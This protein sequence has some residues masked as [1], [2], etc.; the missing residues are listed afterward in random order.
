MDFKKE[1]T[2]AYDKDAH[3]RDALESKR[4]QWKLDLRKQFA[5]LLRSNNK[6]SVLELGSGAGLDAAFFQ[7][8]GFDVLATDLSPEMIKM[9][10]KRGL[11]AQVSDLYNLSTLNKKFDSIFSMNVLLHVPKRDLNLVLDNIAQ[12]LTADGIFFYGVY[13]GYDKEETFTDDSKMGMPRFFSFLSD[14]SI[15]DVVKN[16]FQI[17][18]FKNI[19]IG[20]Y[21]PNA[22][23]QA[24]FLKVR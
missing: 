8:E 20:S 3:R 13:G 21:K 11:K 16:R 24:L 5:E 15:Q 10:K 4:E 23:F 7:A 14:E 12:T 6:R 22:H 2:A 1:L 17:L 19:D 9:C 18:D